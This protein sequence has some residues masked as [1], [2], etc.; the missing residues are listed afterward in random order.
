MWNIFNCC[1]EK[2][3][4][5]AAKRRGSHDCTEVVQMSRLRWKL[6]K[7]GSHIGITDCFGTSHLP[8]EAIVSAVL[9]EHM[10]FKNDSTRSDNTA[11]RVLSMSLESGD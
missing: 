7:T 10:V 4:W 5:K 6:L 2:F 11:N 8:L 9:I 1:V 3:C